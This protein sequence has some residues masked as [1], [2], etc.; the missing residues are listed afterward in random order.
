[1]NSFRL[2]ILPFLMVALGVS[3]CWAQSGL[4]IFFVEADTFFGST[5][6]DGKVSYQ[7][8]KENPA[9]LNKLVKQIGGIS[10]NEAKPVEK[11]AFYI[12]AYNILTIHSII[13][14]G[15]PASPL[16]VDG[17][18][19]EIKHEVAGEQLTLDEIEKDILFSEFKDARVHFAVVCAARGCPQLQPTAYKPQTLDEQLNQAAKK[20]LNR[21]YFTRVNKEKESVKVSQLFKWYRQ[22]FLKEADSVLAYINQYRIEKI[23]GD[24]IVEY[25]EYDWSLNSKL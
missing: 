5:I 18:F 20:T 10:L 23:P 25:Y 13:E 2:Y 6:R 12:N 19:N 4:N 9:Q 7:E 17:F 24:F 1:M 22:D 16:D 11:K 15:I 3:A 8:I 21:D 14:N